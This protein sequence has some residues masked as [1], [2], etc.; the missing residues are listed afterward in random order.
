MGFLMPS[1]PSAP[2]LPPIP[3]APPAANP[4]SFANPATAQSVA[5]SR[6]RAAAAAGMAAGTDGGELTPPTAR[7]TLLGGGK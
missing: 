1:A 4:P 3:P 2:E 7:A 6:K 5:G